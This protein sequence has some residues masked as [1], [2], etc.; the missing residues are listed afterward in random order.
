MSLKETY[1]IINLTVNEKQLKRT[2]QRCR[3]RNIIMPTFAVLKDPAKVPASI[4]TELQKVGLWEVNPRNLF[5]VTWKN[6][7]IKTGGQ[8]DGVNFMELLPAPN[9]IST[10][11]F[12]GCV[13]MPCRNSIIMTANASIT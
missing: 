4:K 7:P 2:A 12:W 1:T 10:G 9:A 11:R 6:E 3:E 8:Y 5:R 13:P